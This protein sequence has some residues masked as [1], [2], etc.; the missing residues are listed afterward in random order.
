MQTCTKAGSNVLRRN[1]ISQ[2]PAVRAKQNMM[3]SGVD[4]VKGDNF[5]LR[6]I[7]KVGRR[8]VRGCKVTPQFAQ[9][10][11]VS[12]FVDVDVQVGMVSPFG[13]RPFF[14]TWRFETGG[15]TTGDGV[16]G[17]AR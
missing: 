12:E 11:D 15:S 4:M 2:N 17:Y 14:P 13:R 9:S 10:W 6:R 5:E 3:P 1:I 16:K 7:D 8:A